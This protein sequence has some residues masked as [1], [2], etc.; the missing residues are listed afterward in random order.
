MN[1][2]EFEKFVSENYSCEADFPW[3]KYP[4]FEVFRHSGNKK[5]FAIVMDIPKEKL[6]LQGKDLLDVVNFKC[7][8][9]MLG[10][11]LGKPGY[12][13]AYHMN[14]ENWITVSLD[15]TAPD[16]EIKILADMSFSATA[17]KT[18]KK[19]PGKRKS[20]D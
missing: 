8:P 2:K 19:K 5:W 13:P 12:F 10:S 3:I 18:R 7:D 6:G 16:N 14:K 9:I 20:S 11:F 1:R 15:G 17:P 4:N